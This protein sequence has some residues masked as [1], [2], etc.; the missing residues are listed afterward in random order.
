MYSCRIHIFFVMSCFFPMLC[1]FF[2]CYV[3]FFCVMSCL[4]YYIDFDTYFFYSYNFDI[5]VYLCRVH[6]IIHIMSYFLSYFNYFRVMF[7]LHLCSRI[8]SSIVGLI[9]HNI[10]MRINGIGDVPNNFKLL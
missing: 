7:N 6:V 8:V 10:S 9:V 2:P 5:F 3:F 4:R 1:V